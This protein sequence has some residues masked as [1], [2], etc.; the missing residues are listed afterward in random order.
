V[1][2]HL[3][4]LA[5]A[6]AAVQRSWLDLSAVPADLAGPIVPHEMQLQLDSIIA[7]IEA[8]RNGYNQ[9][10]LNYNAALKQFPARLIVRLMGFSPGGML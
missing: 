4:E 3:V 7:R 1:T 10:L 9:I 5:N 2:P 6:I 8:S